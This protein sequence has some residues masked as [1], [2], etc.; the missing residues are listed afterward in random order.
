M[1]FKKPI[2]GPR[3]RP[4]AASSRSRMFVVF[5][6]NY[7]IYSC[8]VLC[9][10]CTDGGRFI[11]LTHASGRYSRWSSKL[12]SDKSISALGHRRKDWT[13]TRCR[14]TCNFYCKKFSLYPSQHSICIHFS[15][16]TCHDTKWVWQ[17]MFWC[18]ERCTVHVICTV[19]VR[20]RSV[21]KL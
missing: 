2:L 5:I 6:K 21:C 16:I 20:Y 15:F 3:W 14:L 10:Q 19:S 17:V 4:W 18:W 8:I 13:W 7:H 1:L 11:V 12:A 9:H